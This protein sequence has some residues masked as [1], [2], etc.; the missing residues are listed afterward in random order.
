MNAQDVISTMLIKADKSGVG[1]LSNSQKP[2]TIGV[3]AKL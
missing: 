1:N 3:I 2:S